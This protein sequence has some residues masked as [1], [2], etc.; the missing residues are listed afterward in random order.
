LYPPFVPPHPDLISGF[1]AHLCAVLKQLKM[2]S[3]KNLNY[4]LVLIVLFFLALIVAVFIYYNKRLNGIA[5]DL[6]Q[7]S[8]LSPMTSDQ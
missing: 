5:N 2:N 1:G 8:S 4:K 6:K 7:T 3:L